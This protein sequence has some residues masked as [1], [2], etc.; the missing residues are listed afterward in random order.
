MSI[1]LTCGRSQVQVLYRPPEKSLET[2]VFQGFF[3]DWRPEKTLPACPVETTLALI[4]SK[5]KVPT[6]RDL[7]PGAKRWGEAYKAQN[8]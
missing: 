3:E 2:I 4:S 7:L 5:R 1:R 6:L 8:L